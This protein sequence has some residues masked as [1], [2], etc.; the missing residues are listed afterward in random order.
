MNEEPF[1]HDLTIGCPV[2]GRTYIR[3]PETGKRYFCE[4]RRC[5]AYYLEPLAVRPEY[6]YW[7][8]LP[9]TLLLL[10]VIALILSYWP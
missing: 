8:L 6:N 7:A 2:C 10:G 5:H 9:T 4:C 1:T 3:N